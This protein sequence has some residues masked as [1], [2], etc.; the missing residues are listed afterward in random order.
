MGWTNET[1]NLKLPLFTDTDKPSWRGDFNYAMATLDRALDDGGRFNARMFGVVGDG[2]TDDTAA[3]RNLFRAA[4]DY[5]NNVDMFGRKA[6]LYF[7]VGTYVITE[8][9]V[10][11]DLLTTNNGGLNIVGEGM[12]STIFRLVTNGVEKWFYDNGP[13]RRWNYV[14]ISDCGFTTDGSNAAGTTQANQFGGFM[15]IHSSG[16]EQFFK[17][18]RC[19]FIGP[20]KIFIRTEGTGNADQIALFACKVQD[21]YG[22]LMY[23]NNQQS[24][25]HEWYNV[26]ATKLYGHGFTV[27]PNG[28][29]DVKLYGGSWVLMGIDA[30]TSQRYLFN[31]PDAGSGLGAGNGVFTATGVKVETHRAHMGLVTTPIS[32]VVRV[33]FR[34]SNLWT[35]ASAITQEQINVVNVG[36]RGQVYFENCSLS[37]KFAATV[38]GG[39][40]AQALTDGETLLSLVGCYT[41]PDITDRITVNEY[42]RA[43]GTRLAGAENSGTPRRAMDFDLGWDKGGNAGPAFTAKRAVIRP[44]ERGWPTP[45]GASEWTLRLPRG[46]RITKIYARHAA[47]GAGQTDTYRLHVGNDDKTVTY[48]SSDAA[49]TGAVDVVINADL[50][51]DTSLVSNGRNLRLWATGTLASPGAVGGPVWVEYI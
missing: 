5:T 4:A 3:I 49:G 15:K 25:I 14:T 41:P 43:I 20:W 51:T 35:T 26:T 18:F 7:P 42:G 33:I 44:T 48:A 2:V 30:D 29:G 21:V 28:G 1:D 23:I 36:R 47:Q 19:H 27:G 32:S 46:A 38:T 10:F 24:V 22:H 6:T 16:H 17:F 39:T 34:D 8:N 50:M 40:P 37:P 12:E 13:N 9:N 45:A 31:L 11:A